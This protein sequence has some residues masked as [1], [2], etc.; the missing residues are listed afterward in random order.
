[1]A[2]NLDNNDN[3]PCEFL[4]QVA[5]KHPW[6]NVTKIAENN[7]Q[8]L[9]KINSIYLENKDKP[10]I[11]SSLIKAIA[12]NKVHEIDASAYNYDM[13]FFF[14]EHHRLVYLE[15]ATIKYAAQINWKTKQAFSEGVP[16]DILYK[17][18]S[19][20]QVKAY[21][22]ALHNGASQEILKQIET[23]DSNQAA[24]YLKLNNDQ[25]SQQEYYSLKWLNVDFFDLAE[26]ALDYIGG[27]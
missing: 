26:Q 11:I 24:A 7:R 5:L 2:H 25:T 12:E 1:M 17:F 3:I 27:I 9:P 16:E 23:M 22:K 19:D 20:V 10:E 21:G 8:Y 6:T 18:H 15:G 4:R 14:Q 13:I